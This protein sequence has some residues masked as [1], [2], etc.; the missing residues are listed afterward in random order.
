MKKIGSMSVD[1]R[2]V[3][4]EQAFYENGRVAI[5]FEHGTFGKLTVNLPDDELAE[6]CIHVKTWFENE[7]LRAP[8]LATGLFTDTGE[9][10]ATG[11]CTAEVWK[12][13]P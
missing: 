7:K 9:R 12:F 13:H 10:V 8:A 1:G 11:H 4:I 3:S 5:V 2:T 6:G